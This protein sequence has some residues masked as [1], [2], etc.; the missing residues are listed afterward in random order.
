MRANHLPPPPPASQ[1]KVARYLP[2]R[3]AIYFIFR[4]S[5]IT[6]KCKHG[7]FVQPNSA[8]CFCMDLSLFYVFKNVLLANI[9]FTE[10]TSILIF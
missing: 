5:N 7:E 2:H 9:L 3:F 8:I 6:L 4:T 1:S 10:S